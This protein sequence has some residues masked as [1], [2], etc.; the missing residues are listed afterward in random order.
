MVETKYTKA[1]PMECY[2]KILRVIVSISSSNDPNVITSQFN[3]VD[4]LIDRFDKMYSNTIE[5]DKIKGFLNVS[6]DLRKKQ[7]LKEIQDR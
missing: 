2:R 7:I 6:K 1:T 5:L 3:V 4:R